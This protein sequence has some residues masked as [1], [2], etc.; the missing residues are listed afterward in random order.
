M[1]LWL[2]DE[3]LPPEGWIHVRTAQAA[4]DCLLRGGVEEISLDHDLSTLNTGYD[5]L[6]FIEEAIF[7][8]VLKVLPIIH[9]HTA[10]PV[11]RAKMLQAVEAI[12][13]LVDEL[14]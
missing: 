6:C 14:S 5:V 3:R 12:K 11:G 4:I 2:D 10:N 9:I 7:Q 8:S 13:R 1:K